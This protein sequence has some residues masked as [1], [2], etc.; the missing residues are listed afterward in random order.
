MAQRRMFSITVIDTDLFLEMPQSSRLLYYDLS[1][2]ADDDGFVASPKKIM[3]MIGCSDDDLKILIAKQYLIPFKTGICAI[4]HWKVHNY[5][6]SDRYTQTAYKEEKKLLGCENNVYTLYTEC[7]HSV[8]RLDTEC[9]QNVSIMDTECIQSVYRMDTQVRLGKDRLGEVNKEREPKQKYG[10]YAHVLLTEDQLT[11]LNEEYTAETTLAAIT[12]LDEYIQMKGYKANDHNLCIRKWVLDA[13]KE[14]ETKSAKPMPNTA[15][16]TKF[17]NATTNGRN[18]IDYDAIA[19]KQRPILEH[20]S[21]A[22]L[23]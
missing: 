22:D 2:R 1:M 16:P 23:K 4:K 21:Y 11:K 5:I 15:K 10:E 13:L 20:I 6:Q 18:G 17:N 12:H 9:I 3:K 14:K 19:Q 7:I 8:S